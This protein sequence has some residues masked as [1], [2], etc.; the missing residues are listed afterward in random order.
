M[1]NSNAR[2]GIGPA[3]EEMAPFMQASA[4]ERRG[5]MESPVAENE[6]SEEVKGRM[7]DRAKRKKEMKEMR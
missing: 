7:L 2:T 4:M 6:V 1:M 3:A 5:G